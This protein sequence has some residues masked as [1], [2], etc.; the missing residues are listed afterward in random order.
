MRSASIIR[1]NAGSEEFAGGKNRVR[2]DLYVYDQTD[3]RN[4]PW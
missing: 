1:E 4:R 2:G 3:Q